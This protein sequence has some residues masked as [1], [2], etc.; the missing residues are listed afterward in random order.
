MKWTWYFLEMII[1][2]SDQRMG[3]PF[4]EEITAEANAMLA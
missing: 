2:P 4:L 3:Y 1:K